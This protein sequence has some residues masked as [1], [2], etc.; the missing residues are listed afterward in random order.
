MLETLQGSVAARRGSPP[1]TET[2][3]QFNTPPSYNLDADHDDAPL[4]YRNMSE[5]I[6]PTTPPGPAFRDV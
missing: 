5:I 1:Q 3:S 4:R 6:G 2:A